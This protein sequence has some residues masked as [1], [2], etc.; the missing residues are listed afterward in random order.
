MCQT[1]RTSALSTPMPK[2]LVATTTSTSPR[3]EAAAASRCAPRRPCRRGREPA[4]PPRRS[5]ATSSVS[6]GCRSRRSRAGSP[7]RRGP[8]R[9]GPAAR[10]LEPSP[11]SRTTSKERL[12]GRSPSGH[13]QRLAQAEAG[14]DLRAT[15]VAVAVQAITVGRPSRSAICGQAQVVGSEVVAPLRDAVR[16]VDREQVDRRWARASRKTVEPKRSGEQ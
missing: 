8:L 9:A 2:A 4:A 5:P 10:A 13:L 15:L 1:E 11:S 16:L 7:G 6:C 3:H 12:G 14:D